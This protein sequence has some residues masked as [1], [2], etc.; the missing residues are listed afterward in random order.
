MAG[1]PAAGD[2]EPFEHVR[3]IGRVDAG[4]VVGD[5]EHR[6][7][8]ERLDTHHHPGGRV[9][10]RVLDQVRS[11]L[12]EPV[13]VG[14]HRCRDGRGDRP[15]QQPALGRIGH[16]PVDGHL[17]QL[18]EIERFELEREAR[19][20]QLGEVEQIGHQP[21]EPPRLRRDHLGRPLRVA[22]AVGDG[23]GVPA[24]RRERG[25]QIVAHRQQELLLEGPRPF[26]RARHLVHV[27]RQLIEL[28]AA[29]AAHRQP[30]GQLARGDAGRRSR[31]RL[32]RSRDPPPDEHR[33]E[34]RDRR[35]RCR[36]DHEVPGRGSEPDVGTSG[37]YD[38]AAPRIAQVDRCSGHHQFALVG[39]HEPPVDEAVDVEQVRGDA[40]RQPA[41]VETPVEGHDGEPVQIDDPPQQGELAE[42][43]VD[44]LVVER[45][46]GLVEEQRQV[47]RDRRGLCAQ[48]LLGVG[49]RPHVRQHERA[50][51]GD[52]ERGGHQAHHPDHEPAG[53]RRI[54]PTSLD[55]PTTLANA[56]SL[57]G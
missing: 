27:A 46:V 53:H 55:T 39:A 3:Q 7:A 26:E 45:C 29:T 4:A 8:G 34:Q 21:L 42:S 37:E 32:D 17:G 41:G 47:G 51:A 57:P 33:G 25:A 28:V 30:R 48:L 12:T 50:E 13:A 52:H 10:H 15:Q 6:L 44:G 38:G 23:L 14:R 24:D 22:G 16:E 2:V 35:R 20:L 49:S 1:G 9:L 43:L 54:G 11:H 18:T 31:G 5:G 40:V 36:C 56:F 19:R